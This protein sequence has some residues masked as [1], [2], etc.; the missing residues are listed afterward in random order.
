MDKMKNN[1]N[2]FS[3]MLLNF[4]RA[5]TIL[6]LLTLSTGCGSSDDVGGVKP[7]PDFKNTL[8]MGF[9]EI[10]PGSFMMGS[11]SNE[12]GR[13]NTE[14]LHKVSITKPYFIQTTEVTKRQWIAFFSNGNIS[15][16]DECLKE[17]PDDSA[18]AC[19]E[20]CET[21]CLDCPAVR[22][23]WDQVQEFIERLNCVEE[24]IERLDCEEG[25][26]TITY[27]LPTEAEWEYA[28]RADSSTLYANGNTL[29]NLGWF[30]DNSQDK[31]QPVATKRPND[32][33]VYDMHGNVEEWCQDSYE[34]YALAGETTDPLVL[35]EETY[36]VRRGGSWSDGAEN[37]RSAS[38]Y[39]YNAVG[40]S[41]T[42][43]FRL[44]MTRKISIP[45]E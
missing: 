25:D 10:Q 19:P 20:E 9:N 29:N 28:S 43:G 6:S 14:V 31:A 1:I 17:A 40:S 4:I 41:S 27:R 37:C 18:N 13:D 38:R 30:N 3:K 15:V 5:T 11:P 33:G 45:N 44:V 7:E 35:N 39:K 34:N 26:P 16:C 21:E 8:G 12:Q 2:T 32:W 22:V 42:I 24:D 23:S 36:K